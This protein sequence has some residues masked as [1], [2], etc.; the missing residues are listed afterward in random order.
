MLILHKIIA[1]DALVPRG[2]NNLDLS[3]E[4]CSEKR[5]AL[6]ELRGDVKNDFCWCARRVITQCMVFFHNVRNLSVYTIVFG[7]SRMLIKT[8]FFRDSTL[9]I[10]AQTDDKKSV[11]NF[12]TL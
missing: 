8:P 9:F 2:Q 4:Q 10:F 6:S 12:Y 1:L 7:Y 5:F 3:S 11:E